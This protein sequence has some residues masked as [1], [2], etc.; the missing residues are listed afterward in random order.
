MRAWDFVSSLFFTT[1]QS[2]RYKETFILLLYGFALRNLCESTKSMLSL[3]EKLKC[4]RIATIMMQCCFIYIRDLMEQNGWKKIHLYVYRYIG[5]W[6]QVRPQKIF[7]CLMLQICF[8]WQKMTTLIRQFNEWPIHFKAGGYPPRILFSEKKWPIVWPIPW[9]FKTGGYPP[10]SIDMYR[11]FVRVKLPHEQ[12]TVL[13]KEFKIKI[14]I[15]DGWNSAFRLWLVT[16]N[17]FSWRHF[18]IS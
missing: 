10:V 16:K 9:H 11:S 12:H 5:H 2:A 4:N 7:I 6:V 14:S 3:T 15:K 17:L 8:V 18:V 13:K 1:D